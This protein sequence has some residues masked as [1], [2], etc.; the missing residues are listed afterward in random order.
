MKPTWIKG[1][2]ATEGT[3][4]GGSSLKEGQTSR[5]GHQGY[6]Q[7]IHIIHYTGLAHVLYASGVRI[8]KA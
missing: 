5:H 1:S 8:S 4:E 6:G 7:H 2:I 3:Q